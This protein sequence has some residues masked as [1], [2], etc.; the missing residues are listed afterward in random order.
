VARGRTKRFLLTGF[1]T[2]LPILLTLYLLYTIVNKVHELMGSKF[3]ELFGV[4]ENSWKVFIGDAVALG[5]LLFI[6]WLAG[7]LLATY[8][9]RAFFRWLD[10]V[11]RRIPLVRV[12]YPALKQV[13]DFFLAR[14]TVRFSRVIAVEYPRRGMY[15][16][17]F[18][19]GDG[20]SQVRAPDGEQLMSVFVPSSPAPFTGYTIFIRRSE[21]IPLSLSVDEA[22]K[23]V[24]SGGVVVPERERLKPLEGEGGNDY[25][26]PPPERTEVL[27][28]G[29]APTVE[30]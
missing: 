5:L 8:V 20:L 30:N 7:F 13:T 17:G 3:N 15:S 11:Y 27:P 10:H 16:M 12:V 21:V 23:L 9:G 4:P 6:V 25:D 29:E 2:L 1:A 19:T 18:V 28:P 26:E 22:I 14:Q 24:I